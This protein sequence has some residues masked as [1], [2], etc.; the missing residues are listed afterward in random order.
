MAERRSPRY[1]PDRDRRGALA[2]RRARKL[3]RSTCLLGLFAL[4]YLLPLFVVVLNSF[5]DLPEIA[6]NG[7]IA[8]PRA[9]RFD[10]WGEAWSDLL[11][12]RHLRGH[13]AQFLQ[14]A[15]G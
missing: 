13:A 15:A 10:A 6:A 4:V 1:D 2:A 8:L 14:L 5:R 7:L 3:G 9:S 11:H 12:R